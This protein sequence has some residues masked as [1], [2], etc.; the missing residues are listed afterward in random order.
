MGNLTAAAFASRRP[1]FCFTLVPLRPENDGPRRLNELPKGRNGK[2]LE[3]LGPA[4]LPVLGRPTMPPARSDTDP[5]E[6][7]GTEVLGLV[8]A[9]RGRRRGVALSC[10]GSGSSG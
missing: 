5:E 7:A 4:C 3:G 6:G 2:L 8:S 9:R 1:C 10:D